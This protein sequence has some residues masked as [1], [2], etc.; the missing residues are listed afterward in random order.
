LEVGAI[1]GGNNLEAIR[2][3]VNGWYVAVVLLKQT[4]D[5]RLAALRAPEPFV[6]LIGHA[7]EIK[8][9]SLICRFGA[10]QKTA[11]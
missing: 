8:S 11:S 5:T 7:R 3:A 4:G 2:H 9:M 1:L 10:G 6:P